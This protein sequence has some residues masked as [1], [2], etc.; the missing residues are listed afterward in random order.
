MHPYT[1]RSLTG[2]DQTFLWEV[3]YHAIHVPPGASPPPPNIVNDPAVAKYVREWGRV[4]D[5]GVVVTHDPTN[6]PVGAAWMRLFPA[7]DPGYGFIAEDVPEISI[8]LL[9]GHR[10]R[11][12]G[13]KLIA[14]L[15]DH[16]QTRYPALSLSVV[17]SNPAIH[18]YE[19]LCFK[20]IRANG[21]SLTMERLIR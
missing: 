21:N 14:H 7:S 2:D 17:S 10:D 18:L 12:I 8:A 19:R 16:A 20:E 15:A 3:V 11:G 6:Q 9:P 4:G 13:T 1:I 5:Y